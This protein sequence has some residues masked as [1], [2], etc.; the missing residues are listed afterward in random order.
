MEFQFPFNLTFL[1]LFLSFLF[2]VLSKWKKSKNLSKKLPPGPWKLPILG[3]VHHLALEGGL[4]HHAL[5]NLAK[6][7]RPDL[8][9]LQLAFRELLKDQEKFK[10][11][12]I[13]KE[14]LALAGGFSVAEIFPSIKMFH[15]LSGMRG[16]I[17]ST[18][19]RVDAIVEDVINE[20]KKNIASGK[21]GNGAL[22]GEDL[23]DVLLRLK[24]SG[25]LQIPIT[26]DNI[27]AVMIVSVLAHLKLFLSRKSWV[28]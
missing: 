21:T 2:L 20:H 28:V 13:L 4:P 8:M 5:A 26:N 11:I 23:V 25:E 10:F 24:E 7:Y 1:F 3:S 27:K 17:L 19:K 18:H 9:H 6:K 12:E 22:G 15:L 16:R 14:V